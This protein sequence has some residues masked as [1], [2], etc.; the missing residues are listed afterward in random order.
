MHKK[1]L[2]KCRYEKQSLLPTE[3]PGERKYGS[4]LNFI[5]EYEYVHSNG[6]DITM[7]N[8]VMGLSTF[9]DLETCSGLIALWHN[10]RQKDL[11]T[12][13]TDL[14]DFALPASSQTWTTHIQLF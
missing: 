8:P 6:E 7:K 1:N 9:F 5:I 4:S 3:S 14:A 13:I 10:A 11:K 2:G 12:P